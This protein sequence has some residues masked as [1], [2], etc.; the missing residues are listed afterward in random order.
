MGLLWDSYDCYGI[1]MIATGLLWDSYGI[2]TIA[3]G[4]LWD[5]YDCDGIPMIVMGAAPPALAH[6]RLEAIT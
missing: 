2:P 3:M 4:L 5:C 1:P 6:M